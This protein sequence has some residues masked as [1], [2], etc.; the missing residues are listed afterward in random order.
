VEFITSKLAE[1][2]SFYQQADHIIDGI[3]LSVERLVEAIT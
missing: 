3:N 1:R 2:E